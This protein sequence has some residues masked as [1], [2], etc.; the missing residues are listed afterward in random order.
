MEWAEALAVFGQYE[1]CIQE[2]STVTIYTYPHF[3]VLTAQEENQEIVTGIRFRSSDVETARGSVIGDS[4]ETIIKKEGKDY[5]TDGYSFLSYRKEKTVL[6]FMLD[7]DG[8]VYAIEYGRVV[9]E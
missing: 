9:E 5:V 4:K 6:S 1:T 7:E 8:S 2:D 3:M